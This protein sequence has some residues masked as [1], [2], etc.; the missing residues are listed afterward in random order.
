LEGRVLAGATLLTE[1]IVILAFSIISGIVVRGGVPVHG[2]G[3]TI[4]IVMAFV[5]VVIVTNLKFGEKMGNFLTRRMPEGL[6]IFY[7]AVFCL[8]LAFLAGSIGLHAVLGAFV[9]GLFLRFLRLRDMDGREYSVEWIIMPAR[10]ILVPIF[11]VRV[12]ALVD[13]QRFLDPNAVLLALAIAGAAI[14]GKLFCSV[15][16]IE[17]GINRIAIGVGMVT[18]LEGT[19][20][21]SGIGRELGVVDEVVFS[22]LVFV[23]VITSTACPSLLKLILSRKREELIPL[24]PPTTYRKKEAKTFERLKRLGRR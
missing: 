19:L 2:V 14:L 9:A 6:K 10:M 11:F 21:L 15:C 20:I 1:I 4:G 17:R 22:S 3:I 18:K 7:A 24:T 12:G 5:A 16:P 8:L 13:W 23:I